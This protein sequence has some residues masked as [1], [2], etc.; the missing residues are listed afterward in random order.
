[1]RRAGGL[2]PPSPVAMRGGAHSKGRP[3]VV[4]R[5]RG[6]GEWG[7]RPAVMR[8]GVQSEG[9]GALGRWARRGGTGSVRVCG[10]CRAAGCPAG[11][12]SSCVVPVRVV[13]PGKIGTMRHGSAAYASSCPCLGRRWAVRR[14]AGA[15]GCRAH[16]GRGPVR[17]AA[18][19]CPDRRGRR[20]GGGRQG[21]RGGSPGVGGGA[22]C[23]VRP[24]DAAGR[25]YEPGQGVHRRRRCGGGGG[26]AGRAARRHRRDGPRGMRRRAGCDGVR[27]V[28]PGV[29]RA[30]SP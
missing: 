25:C 28:G 3:A 15:A 1:M 14:G 16:P 13:P 10:D 27:G 21:D 20:A 6:R 23:A 24:G 7:T 29:R 18:R 30:G 26:P 12:G 5:E 17:R 9:S 2:R 11:R 19:G 8:G 4:G 22:R